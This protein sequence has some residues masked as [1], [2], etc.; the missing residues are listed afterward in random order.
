MENTYG[1]NPK[2][3]T[4]QCNAEEMNIEA[5]TIQLNGRCP[6]CNTQYRVCVPKPEVRMKV[7]PDNEAY[8][9]LLAAAYK[10]HVA[11]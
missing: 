1:K 4:C 10:V 9:Q 5:I 11:N 7:I 2:R 3:I 8:R 6:V